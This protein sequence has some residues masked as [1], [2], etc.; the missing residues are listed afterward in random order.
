M[1]QKHY[2]Y[3][4][5]LIYAID[6]AMALLTTNVEVTFCEAYQG[7][8]AY[9]ESRARI[10][11]LNAIEVKSSTVYKRGMITALVGSQFWID[12][13]AFVNNEAMYNSAVIFMESNRARHY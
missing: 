2:A 13:T 12:D 11:L 5:G 10:A 4:G 7:V 8:I 3:Y 9:L 1:I 6:G